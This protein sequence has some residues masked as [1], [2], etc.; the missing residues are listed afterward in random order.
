MS[1]L[2]DLAYYAGVGMTKMIVF[3]SVT[4]GSS[5][6][7]HHGGASDRTRPGLTKLYRL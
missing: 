4:P 1:W 6:M 2:N 5:L 3:I 7:R